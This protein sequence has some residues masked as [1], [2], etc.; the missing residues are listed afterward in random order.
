MPCLWVCWWQDGTS[1]IIYL[2]AVYLMAISSLWGGLSFWS[3][4][5]MLQVSH[6]GYMLAA[7]AQVWHYFGK[8]PND[9]IHMKL[10]VS[11]RLLLA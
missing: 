5:M 11:V 3:H 6:S 7:T 2:C 1:W 10:L 9:R 4:I 8:F